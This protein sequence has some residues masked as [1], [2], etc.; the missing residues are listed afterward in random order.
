MIIRNQ[1]TR[2]LNVDFS[3]LGCS[4][5]PGGATDYPTTLMWFYRGDT[6]VPIPSPLRGFGVHYSTSWNE[7]LLRLFQTFLG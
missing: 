7:L 1:V 5:S 2:T 3:I 4:K 6:L